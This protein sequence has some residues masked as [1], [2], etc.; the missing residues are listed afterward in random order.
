M[1]D[2]GNLLSFILYAA[3]LTGPV[4]KLAFMVQQYQ[5]G[6]SGYRRFRE[7]V[8][9]VP[10]VQDAED[11]KELVV[12]VGRVT[13][14][15]V[16]FGYDEGQ[17]YVLKNI[18]M[19]VSPGETVAIVGPSG[20]G[21]TTLCSLIPRFYEVNSGEIY[22]D[23]EEIKNV[24][25]DSLRKKMGIVRQEVF[26][27]SGTVLENILYGK[28]DATRE[29]AIEAAKK[30]Y[31]HEFILELPQGYETSVGQRGVR[32][33]GGQQQR[34]SI[35]RVFLKNPP[36]LIFDEATSALDDESE[37][38]VLASLKTL[39]AGRT[40]L[41]IAHRASTIKDADRILVLTDEGLAEQESQKI[42]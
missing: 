32:L 9:Q 30:A 26:L 23:G 22:I 36:I 40:T 38:V 6:V 33:S 34:I 42:I 31:A 4:P 21:K 27:F 5:E 12:T 16:T 35:A 39:A 13:F 3:Y 8:D 1:Q 37:R 15:Q 2:I 11:A 28:P 14:N 18:N 20:I 24:T 10:C 41:I 29:E 19:E 17:E 7:I 25:L